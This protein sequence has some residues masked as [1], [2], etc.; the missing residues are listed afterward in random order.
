MGRV[1]IS[2][3]GPGYLQPALLGGLVTGVL[4]ALPVISAGNICCCLWVVSGGLLAAYLL[5]QNHQLPITAADGAVVGLLAG[6]IGA[7]IEFVLSIPIGMLV[8]PVERQ[9]LERLRELSGATVSSVPFG[10][11]GSGA[12]GVV[13]LRIIAFFFTL[14]VASVVSTLAGLVGAALFAKSSPPPLPGSN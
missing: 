8:G 11:D 1:T 13:I 6:I 5:Q 4:S 7:I 10:M 9:I 3:R 2:S 14:I 12:V